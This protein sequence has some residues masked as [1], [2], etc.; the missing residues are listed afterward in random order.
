VIQG[1]NV[2]DEEMLVVL[3]SLL[4]AQDVGVWRPTGVPVYTRTETGL[5]YGSVGT[6][7]DRGVALAR[8]GRRDIGKPGD[9][10]RTRRM[11][12]FVRGKPGNIA[13]A[14]RLAQDVD[15]VFQGLSR[16]AG[17]NDVTRLNGPNPLGTD[18]SK[19]SELSLNYTVTLED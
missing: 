10:V 9:A 17:I 4:D 14:D 11:Q 8:Y 18:G 12:A 1:V 7:T 2:T 19:R 13:D 6:E 5:Y 16:H 3:L 15:D